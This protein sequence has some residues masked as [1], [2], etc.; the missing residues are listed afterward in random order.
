MAASRKLVPHA[1]RNVGLEILNSIRQIKRGEPGPLVKT[2]TRSEVSARIPSS[3]SSEPRLE[4]RK[5][6]AQLGLPLPA[7]GRIRNERQSCVSA[8]GSCRTVNQATDRVVRLP[9]ARLRDQLVCSRRRISC[10]GDRTQA[11]EIVG[12]CNLWCVRLPFLDSA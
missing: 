11:R 6:R 5:P 7:A 10:N 3:R 9:Q 4:R 2:S 8:H 1:E 12:A